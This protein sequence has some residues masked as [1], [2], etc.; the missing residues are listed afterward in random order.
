MDV[1]HQSTCREKDQL[2]NRKT[3]DC[4]TV[5]SDAM[6][7]LRKKKGLQVYQDNFYIGNLWRTANKIQRSHVAAAKNS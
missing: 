6:N 5:Y 4:F 7:L 1:R 2:S 3:E